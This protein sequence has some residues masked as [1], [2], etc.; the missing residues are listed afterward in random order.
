MHLCIKQHIKQHVKQRACTRDPL[1]EVQARTVH[2]PGCIIMPHGN[3]A[4]I[5]QRTSSIAKQLAK[6]PPA[7]P[8][9]ADISCAAGGAL[10]HPQQRSLLHL[11]T[12]LAAGLR[13]DATSTQPVPVVTWGRLHLLCP[14]YCL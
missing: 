5:T 11:W 10:L 2:A 13:P 7:A 4:S 1:R 6:Q 3:A 8:A 9:P 12:L 14:A